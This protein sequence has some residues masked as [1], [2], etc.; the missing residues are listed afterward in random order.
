MATGACAQRKRRFKLLVWAENAQLAKLREGEV[1]AHMGVEGDA[2]RLEDD[3]GE[4]IDLTMRSLGA[5]AQERKLLAQQT[6]KAERSLAASRT[7]LVQVVRHLRDAGAPSSRLP[8]R[9]RHTA[10]ETFWLRTCVHL[11]EQNIASADE[12]HLAF[13]RSSID[14]PLVTEALMAHARL[15]RL[16]A[17]FRQKSRGG[18][19]NI[20]LASSHLC[21]ARLLQEVSFH[22]S[23]VMVAK[24][25]AETNH[26][27]GRAYLACGREHQLVSQ[28]TS[29]LKLSE[30][31]LREAVAVGSSLNSDVP[32]CS[33]ANMHADLAALYIEM[34]FEEKL[35][36]Y[37]SAAQLHLFK[38]ADKFAHCR[39]LSRYYPY[40][41]FLARS[42]VSCCS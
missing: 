32:L 41:L 19:T 4:E 10:S 15:A 30:R 35:D 20:E 31:H 3:L 2:S 22:L 18:L 5:L 13:R 39:L 37:L 29:H 26:C 42:H 40:H 36:S 16:F 17:S 9:L 1:L 12:D 25:D 6:E 38:A 27:L 14:G 34:S 21:S 8:G 11:C 28:R 23:E 33:Q 24:D 7:K